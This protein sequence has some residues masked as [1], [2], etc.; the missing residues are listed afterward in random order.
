[1]D[2]QLKTLRTRGDLFVKV[3]TELGVKWAFGVPGGVLEPLYDALYRAD[4]ASSL[5]LVTVRHEAAAVGMAEGVVR[6]SGAIALCCATSGPGALN[7]VTACASALSET[8]PILVVTAQTAMARFGQGPVQDSSDQGTDTVSIF[9]KVT[10]YSSFVSHPDQLLPKLKRAWVLAHQSPCGPVHLSI[11]P[12]ILKQACTDEEWDKVLA[13]VHTWPLL[14]DTRA[15]GPNLTDVL[16][17]HFQGARHPCLV[18][19]RNPLTPKKMFFGS[20]GN[21]NGP[22]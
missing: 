14:T 2:N 21:L 18:L 22:W 8:K 5:N 3:L 10:K 20:W 19:G 17:Q 13:S 9:S 1:M 12:E 11:P 7:M 6:A 15:P 4:L 16:R